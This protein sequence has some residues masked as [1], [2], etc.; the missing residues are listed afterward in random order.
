MVA[1][2]GGEVGGGRGV[3]FAEAVLGGEGLGGWRPG[4]RRFVRAGR[5][6]RGPVCRRRRT[7][8]SACAGAGCVPSSAS[9]ASVSSL[10][11][12]GRS[13]SRLGGLGRRTRSR[14]QATRRV[15]CRAPACGGPC[16]RDSQASSATRALRS[17]A[18]VPSIAAV[19]CAR[20]ALFP[21]EIQSSRVSNQVTSALPA[22][23]VAADGGGARAVGG[24]A[25]VD[26]EAGDGVVE[27]GR[28][29]LVGEAGDDQV[30]AGAGEGHVEE[31][32]LLG[33]LLALLLGLGRV[34]ALRAR[35]CRS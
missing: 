21:A 32:A 26:G 24:L 12:V 28:A 6:G 29:A 13:S 30:V 15:T 20:G 33:L 22:R 14:W 2:A 25:V 10:A 18:S 35:S 27:P 31:A 5:E 1:R 8:W 23:A 16:G 17:S 34:P 3:C 4:R 19:G 11:G 7:G 9:S